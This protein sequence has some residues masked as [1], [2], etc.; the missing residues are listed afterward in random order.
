MIGFYFTFMGNYFSCLLWHSVDSEKSI[1]RK[2]HIFS[3]VLK[4]SLAVNTFVVR[5]W[6][7]DSKCTHHLMGGSICSALSHYKALSYNENQCLIRLPQWEEKLEIRSTRDQCFLQQLLQI[8]LIQW[9]KMLFIAHRDE[10]AEC[11]QSTYGMNS[12]VLGHSLS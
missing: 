3:V 9:I 4:L 6:G 2:P 7:I 12:I 10:D 5:T 8:L 11:Y 1:L